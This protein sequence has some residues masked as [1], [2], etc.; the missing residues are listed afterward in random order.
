MDIHSPERTENGYSEAPEIT[1]LLG[2]LVEH[3]SGVKIKQRTLGAW[4]ELVER[5]LDLGSSLGFDETQIL[6]ALRIV[7][8][9]NFDAK[10]SKALLNVLYP[11]DKVP[12]EAVLKILVFLG[13]ATGPTRWA[14]LKETIAAQY[15]GV[16][17][18][19]LECDNLRLV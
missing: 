18:H 4:V 15:Y 6:L 17:F 19:H 1:Q 16:L 5:L 14:D 11:V 12:L 13:K 3:V 7:Q 10:M 9:P 2:Q 8:S